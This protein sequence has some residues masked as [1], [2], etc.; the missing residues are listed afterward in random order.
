MRYAP[1]EIDIDALRAHK[2]KVVSHLTSGLGQIAK[3]RKPMV[4]FYASN[5]FVYH[6]VARWILST[7][8]FALP[9]LIAGKEIVP[10]LIPHFGPG[11][12]IADAAAKLLASDELMQRQRDE[13]GRVVE[14]FRTSHAGVAGAHAIC[15]VLGIQ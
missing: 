2:E 7:R 9:N 14:R 3:Q 6:L 8:Y 15:E 4:V 1:P 12:P 10:E 5:R 11:G 13:L